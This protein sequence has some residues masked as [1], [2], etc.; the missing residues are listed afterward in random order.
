MT[1]QSN[2]SVRVSPSVS[3]R[4]TAAASGST[5]FALNSNRGHPRGHRE[6]VADRG[7]GLQTGRQ[8]DDGNAVAPGH[9]GELPAGGGDDSPGAQRL[10][11]LVAR[12]RLLRVARIARAEDGAVW[13]HARGQL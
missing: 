7:T 4:A 8:P 12:D 13:Q 5:S 3:T 11:R 2:R 6:R 9:F 1:V 10:G